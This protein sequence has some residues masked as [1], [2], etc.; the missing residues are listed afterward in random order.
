MLR[1]FQK[2][3]ANSMNPFPQTAE[4]LVENS[5]SSTEAI[6]S[7]MGTEIGRESILS[8][9]R[10]ILEIR[11]HVPKDE[12]K[13]P[14][15]AIQQKY[16]FPIKEAAEFS[17]LYPTLFYQATRFPGNP[18]SIERLKAMIEDIVLFKEEEITEYECQK[19]SI[20]N[21]KK[22]LDN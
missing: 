18:M 8:R 5:K 6:S 16:F 2:H 13:L 9:Y 15:A 1:I 4:E 21:A 7:D 22:Q 19:R 14:L 17:V 3:H 12:R 11:D 10:R 20:E